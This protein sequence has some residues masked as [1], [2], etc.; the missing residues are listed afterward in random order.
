MTTGCQHHVAML[1]GFFSIELQWLALYTKNSQIK[2]VD[3]G[4]EILMK[5]FLVSV[6]VVVVTVAAVQ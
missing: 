4:V 6:V 5:T 2:N 1:N 3:I